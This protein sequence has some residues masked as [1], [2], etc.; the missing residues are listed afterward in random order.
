MSPRPH[1][2]IVAQTSG[3]GW[4]HAHCRV[5]GDLGC[6]AAHARIS[7][8][9]AEELAFRLSVSSREL[10][11]VFRDSLG[12]QLK[13]WL[14]ELR[15]LEVRRRLLGAESIQEIALS[16]GFSH[17]KELA[18]EFRRFYHI[19]PS[20]FRRSRREDGGRT[21]CMEEC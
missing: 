4:P 3:V 15:I 10:R 13:K 8:Y 7:G 2:A 14:M 18:R 20:L 17:A 19:T 11:R 6:M 1:L 9:R 5:R 21:D 12:V 16:V